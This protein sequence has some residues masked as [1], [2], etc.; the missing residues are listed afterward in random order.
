MRENKYSKGKLVFARKENKND[1]L[2]YSVRK[3]GIHIV[4]KSVWCVWKKC[5]ST[6]ISEISKKTNISKQ[7]VEAIIRLLLGRELI[8]CNELR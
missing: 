8:G 3:R 5:N 6:S 7:D 4:S 1:Y 2:I